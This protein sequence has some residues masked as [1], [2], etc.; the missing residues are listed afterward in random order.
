[1]Q[2]AKRRDAGLAGDMNAQVRRITSTEKRLGGPFATQANQTDNGDRL[3]Q[4]TK[5]IGLAPT[6]S[7]RSTQP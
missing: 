3:L 5:F 7:I 4:V 2:T 1:M 6:S